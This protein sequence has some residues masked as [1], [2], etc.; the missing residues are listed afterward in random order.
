MLTDQ[1]TERANGTA[2]GVARFGQAYGPA[3]ALILVGIGL[4]E[5]LVRVLDVPT[6]IWPPPSLVAA[7]LR[8]EAGLLA[9]RLHGKYPN[10]PLFHRYAGRTQAA[11]GQTDES[12]ATFGDIVQRVRQGRFGYG[13][14]AEREA[15]A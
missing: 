11:L 7:T 14:V 1:T 5:L 15:A 12:A 10:N 9:A 2:T 6:F 3:L 13:A 4:W 8:D